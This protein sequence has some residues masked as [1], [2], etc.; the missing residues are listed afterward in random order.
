MKVRSYDHNRDFRT[1]LGRLSA[2]FAPGDHLSVWHRARWAYMHHHPNVDGLDRSRFGVAEDQGGI[3][4]IVHQE[5]VPA[6]AYLQIAPGREDA[7]EALLAWAEERLGGWSRALEREALGFWVPRCHTGTVD[8]LQHRRYVRTEHAEPG[9]WL[10]LE[11]PFEPAPLP[12]GYRINTL[13]RDNDLA[14]VNRILWRGFNHPGD[15]PVEE[16][17]GRARGQRAPGF[18]LDRTVVAVAPGG[19]FASYAGIWLDEANRSAYVEPVATDPDHRRRGVGTAAV[20]EVLRL[21]RGDGATHAWVGSDQAFYTSMGF[22]VTCVADLWL[23][24]S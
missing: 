3:V 4:G 13:D 10:D 23:R 17:P 6:F 19:D 22:R 7:I 2:W 21:A 5:H 14:K 11:E 18:R 24:P 15:P 9:A 16:I 8:A 20:L 12:D 1:I